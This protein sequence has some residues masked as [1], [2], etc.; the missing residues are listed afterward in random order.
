MKTRAS[1]CARRLPAVRRRVQRGGCAAGAAVAE[2][3]RLHAVDAPRALPPA[4]YFFAKGGAGG[5]LLLHLLRLPPPR[6]PQTVR[7]QLAAN[8]LPISLQF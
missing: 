2:A 7:W 8:Q 5:Y 3:R 4:P 6:R 1:A